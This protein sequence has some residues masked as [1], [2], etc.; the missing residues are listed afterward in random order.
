MR[1]QKVIRQ[2]VLAVILLSVSTSFGVDIFEMSHLSGFTD[3]RNTTYGYGTYIYAATEN[4]VYSHYVKDFTL[5]TRSFF[6][7]MT[8]ICHDVV[9]RSG[10]TYA[11]NGTNGF[12]VVDCTSPSNMKIIANLKPGGTFYGLD[13]HGIFAYCAAGVD[14]LRVINLGNPSVPVAISQYNTD[15]LA[16]DVTIND[17]ATAYVADGS[18]GVCVINVEDPYT[19]LPRRIIGTPGYAY[20]VD[21][22]LSHLYV[23]DHTGGLRIYD[24]S[25]PYHPAWVSTL[26]LPGPCYDVQVLNGIAY[27]AAGTAG[28]Q[29][30]SVK[31]PAFPRIMASYDTDNAQGVSVNGRQVSISDYSGGVRIFRVTETICDYDGDGKSDIGVYWPAGTSW[32]VRKSSDASSLWGGAIEL[33]ASVSLPI[34]FPEAIGRGAIHYYIPSSG[35]WYTQGSDWY[36]G[37]SYG[38]S[39]TVPV[40]GDYDKDCVTD[41]AVY[42]IATG[43]WYIRESHDSDTVIINWGW[44]ATVPVK[45]DYDGDGLTD[46]AVY[47]PANGTWYIHGST[48]YNSSHNFGWSGAAP[49]P[50]DYDKDGITDLAVYDPATGNWYIKNSSDSSV[51]IA[52]WGWSAAVP[53]PLD[54]DG[55]GAADLAVYW[56]ETGNWYINFSAGSY[57]TINWGWSAASPLWT[58]YWMDKIYGLLP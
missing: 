18:R 19:P 37:V 15:G 6:V 47:Y 14:G 32:M 36:G 40:P 52:N 33:H 31:R 30:V 34:Q 16:R 9:F 21:V 17:G 26:I 50:A 29:I 39:A 56:P 46:P 53:V 11:A 44:N 22:Y 12:V 3:A 24:V 20:G 8:G 10:C 45:G 5:P 43:D 23:A 49:V 1:K 4:R 41:W 28:L 2:I 7:A 57:T 38:W 55:D 51:R 42:H 25:D 54:Y 58:Q 35:S 13:V 27:C 48:G